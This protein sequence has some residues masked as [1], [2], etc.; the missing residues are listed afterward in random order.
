MLDA[1]ADPV[2]LQLGHVPAD[3]LEVAVLVKH[4]ELQPNRCRRD[5]EIGDTH[6]PIGAAR[7]QFA[8]DRRDE[9]LDVVR[10]RGVGIVRHELVLELCASA[11][12]RCRLS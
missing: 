8:P 7:N 2:V 1:G 10:H 6:A 4:A 3:C 12:M 9:V 11:T 5:D